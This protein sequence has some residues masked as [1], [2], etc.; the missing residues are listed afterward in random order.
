M[1]L[2]QAAEQQVYLIE[3]TACKHKA[4]IDLVAMAK[5]L[6]ESFP[7]KDL[8]PRLKCDKCKSKQTIATILWK[9]ATTTAEF[10]RRWGKD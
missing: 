6:G 1:N 9:S 7:L 2:G 8:R 5:S 4:Q 3:C 10:V